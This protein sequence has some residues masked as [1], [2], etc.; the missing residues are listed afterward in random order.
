MEDAIGKTPGDP[1]SIPGSATNSR[2]VER[3]LSLSFCKV[4]IIIMMMTV[5]MTE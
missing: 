2:T 5:T 4:I 1:G 3:A